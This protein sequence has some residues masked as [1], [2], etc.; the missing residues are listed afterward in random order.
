MK[1]GH[2][3]ITL[4]AFFFASSIFGQAEAPAVKVDIKDVK[5]DSIETPQ[6]NAANVP[7]KS[8]RPKK[9]MQ[10]DVHFNVKKGKTN[11]TNPYVDSLEF[12]Y[13]ISLNH[14]DPVTKKF[15]LLTATINYVNVSSKEIQLHA[16]AFVS[17]AAIGRLLGKADFT[18]ADVK[19]I[20]IEVSHGG[21]LV[22][23]HTEGAP[24]KWWEDLTKFSVVDGNLLPKYKTPFAPL[25]GDYDVNVKEQ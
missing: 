21:Q 16:M 15:I 4:L 5:V 6:I 9:W 23:G 20:G 19:G 24:G 3:I 1:A 18:M 13:F 12:K 2:Y 22:G 10:M 8:W 14:V 7:A 25:W 17:P 11:D